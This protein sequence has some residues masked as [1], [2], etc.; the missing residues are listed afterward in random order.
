M[1]VFGS[2]DFDPWVFVSGFGSRNLCLGSQELISEFVSQDLNLGVS[3]SGFESLG[4]VLRIW[5]P[6]FGT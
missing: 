4:L 3:V 2:L 1:S 5:I 6:G